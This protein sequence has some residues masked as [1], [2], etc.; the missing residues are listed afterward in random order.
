MRLFFASLLC[1]SP[2]GCTARIGFDRDRQS[3]EPVTDGTAH[4]VDGDGTQP[5]DTPPNDDNQIP[6][7]DVPPDDMPLAEPLPPSLVF[8]QQPYT[9][10]AAGSEIPVR[11]HIE[12]GEGN[13]ITSGADALVDIT[14]SLSS[15]TGPLRGN[16]TVPTFEGVADFGLH[17]VNLLTTG[18]G[19]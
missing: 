16:L 19:I 3:A 13:I 4:T 12:D 1:V 17:N 15:G 11:V 7:D 10:T 2:F 6:P 5:S 14:L 18:G 8:E 9:L